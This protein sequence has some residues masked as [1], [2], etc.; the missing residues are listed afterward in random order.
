MFVDDH[1]PC[2]YKYI[3]NT[4]NESMFSEGHLIFWWARMVFLHYTTL[5]IFEF[6]TLIY[7][8]QLK[9]T[10][11]DTIQPVWAWSEVSWDVGGERIECLPVLV[12][13]YSAFQK[14][15][16]TQLVWTE[17]AQLPAP[18]QICLNKN[19]CA[20]NIVGRHYCPYTLFINDSPCTKS[21]AISDTA[22]CTFVI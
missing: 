3:Y 20:F 7:P 2:T 12:R 15:R 13:L 8:T 4:Y 19:R 9:L 10:N 18:L 16:P 1:H 17:L 5:L 11:H 6:I 21:K 22:Q 14:A